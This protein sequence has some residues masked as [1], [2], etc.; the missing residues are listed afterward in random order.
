MRQQLVFARSTFRLDACARLRPRHRIVIALPSA[1]FDPSRPLSESLQVSDA[2]INISP[3]IDGFGNMQAVLVDL[4]ANS[5]VAVNRTTEA[6]VVESLPDGVEC[7]LS[8]EPD[9]NV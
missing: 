7:D 3:R 2:S 4:P 9:T 5:W 6:Y 8:A 1:L